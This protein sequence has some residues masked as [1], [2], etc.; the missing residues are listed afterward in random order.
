MTSVHAK[1]Y[2][3][4]P[5]SIQVDGNNAEMCRRIEDTLGLYNVAWDSM[6]ASINIDIDTSEESAD[7]GAGS[8]L[9]CARMHV[10]REAHY[11]KATFK[12]GAAAVSEHNGWHLRVP[13]N[14]DEFWTLVDLESFVT[15]VLTEGWRACG[16]VPV[17]A[18]AIVRDKTCAMVC[19]ESGGGKTSLTSAMLSRGWQTLGDDK[20]LLRI[21]AS[22][23]AELRALVHTFNMHPRTGGWFPEV[24]DVT[25]L[26]SY[27]VFTDKRKIHPDSIWQGATLDAARPT[28]IVKL[29]RGESE[30]SIRARQLSSA[31]TLSTLLHQTVIPSEAAAAKPIVATIARTAASLRG[32]ELEVGNNAYANEEAISMIEGALV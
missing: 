9:T 10:D 6:C 2:A 1:Q 21:D 18:A 29:L 3:C 7:L 4:G 27:S 24:G 14:G 23:R 19:A 15:L 22:G 20:L 32:I 25:E 12:S 26:P 30:G 5:L 28:H 8:Y 17:H 31:E 13:R 11:L 16:W